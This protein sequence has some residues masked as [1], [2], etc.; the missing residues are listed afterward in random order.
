MGARADDP[1]DLEVHELFAA[2]GD[3]PEEEA[4]QRWA[5]PFGADLRAAWAEC[6]RG[7]W[8]LRLASRA[9]VDEKLYARAGLMVA[10]AALDLAPEALAVVSSDLETLLA[11]TEGRAGDDEARRAASHAN[12][13]AS[14]IAGLQGDPPTPWRDERRRRSQAMRSLA[15]SAEGG[16]V[17]PSA[18][19]LARGVAKAT[20]GVRLDDF[21]RECVA[22]IR[23]VIS[24]EALPRNLARPPTPPPPEPCYVEVRFAAPGQWEALKRAWDL[25]ASMKGNETLDAD[26]G[27]WAEHAQ[28]ERLDTI[29]QAICSLTSGEYEM[30]PAVL[31]DPATGRLPFDPWAFPYGGV[32]C[33]CWLAEAFGCEVLAHDD[34][35]GRRGGGC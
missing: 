34:G 6:P 16:N 5:R 4:S 10:S 19:D 33:M 23:R 32:A 8:L 22:R 2:Y 30:M 12:R 9:R 17:W 11:W 29:R 35:T 1:P 31:I 25:A 3:E 18:A 26:A 27:V 28:G 13:E 21:D 15:R 24:S 20:A 7:G 14:R